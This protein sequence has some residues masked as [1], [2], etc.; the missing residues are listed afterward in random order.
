[1][2]LAATQ[3]WLQPQDGLS[4]LLGKQWRP[5]LSGFWRYYGMISAEF[6]S[7][8]V[9]MQGEIE[10]ALK[11]KANPAFRSKYADLGACWD[12]CRDALQ[13]NKLAVLQFVTEAPA[14]SVG[15]KTAIFFGPTG[16]S[17]SET[18]FI[19]VKDATNP[20]ALGSAVTYGRRY[21]LCAAIGICP[22]DDDGNSAAAVKA[23]STA[24]KVLP[25]PSLVETPNVWA[26]FD[27]L[28]DVAQQKT[29]YSQVKAMVIPEP[30][31]TQL[32]TR[33]ANKIKGV[34]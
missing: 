1:M 12:A 5:L 16:E 6:A 17:L 34:K 18:A 13:A 4:V 2:T 20:Q 26:Q 24:S 10:G 11:G 19:P 8:L 7:A 21:G 28:P 31:K 29:F 33:M 23:T 27:A 14:G 25:G 9:K 22:E 32:L 3:W 15:I 30:E